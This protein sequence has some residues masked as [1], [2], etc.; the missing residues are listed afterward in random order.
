[1][2]E[3]AEKMDGLACLHHMTRF[4]GVA[5]QLQGEICFAGSVQLRWP[6]RIDSPAAVGELPAAYVVGKFGN[7]LRI[8]LSQNVQIVD[9]I[10]FEGGVRF[11]LALPVSFRCLDGKEM[12]CAALDGFF[13]TLHP[14]LF[15]PRRRHG[16]NGN[17][18]SHSGE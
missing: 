4:R 10:G 16:S 2:L 7:T 3:A 6:T 15:L 17:L 1:M 8:G 14:I 9:V 13:K 5:R 12:I 18:L 11:E